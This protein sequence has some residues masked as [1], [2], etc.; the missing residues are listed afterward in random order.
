MYPYGGSVHEAEQRA[1]VYDDTEKYT[2]FCALVVQAGSWDEADRKIKRAY[3]IEPH[4][5]DDTSK[6]GTFGYV[7][8]LDARDKVEGIDHSRI[9][10]TL[11][12]IYPEIPTETWVI[13]YSME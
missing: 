7:Y 4:E 9:P 10:D 13:D 2:A 11:A 5:C 6:I 12:D 1:G 8:Y 3:D